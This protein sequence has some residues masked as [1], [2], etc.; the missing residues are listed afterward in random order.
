[1]ISDNELYAL[2]RKQNVILCYDSGT[3]FAWL[4]RTL[5]PYAT[6]K[7]PENKID[8]VLKNGC[9]PVTLK[10]IS[11]NCYISYPKYFTV[12]SK[13]IHSKEKTVV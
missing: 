8:T 5:L 1:M 11:A 3:T 6:K 7:T 4:K 2:S 13:K 10:R 12:N 9:R